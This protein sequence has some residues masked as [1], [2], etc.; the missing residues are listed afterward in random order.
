[1]ALVAVS[2]SALLLDADEL[3][4]THVLVQASIR[5]EL[6]LMHVLDLLPMRVPLLILRN[7]LFDSL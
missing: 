1:M 6:I 4:L 2:R 5:E 7:V 3:A